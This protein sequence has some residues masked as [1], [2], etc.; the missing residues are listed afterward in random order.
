M[1]WYL[2][3]HR[4][5]NETKSRIQNKRKNFTS[6]KSDISREQRKNRLFKNDADTPTHVTKLCR[7]KYTHEYKYREIYTD[8][9]YWCQDPGCDITL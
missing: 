9:V 3:Q 8:G 7:I 2:S 4:Q 5:I 1:F 6:D